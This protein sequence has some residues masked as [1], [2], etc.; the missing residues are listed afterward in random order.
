[1]SGLDLSRVSEPMSGRG[2]LRKLERF[3]VE[4]GRGMLVDGGECETLTVANLLYYGS[5]F[6]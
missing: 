3:Y 6:S 1:M 5:E 2:A 4:V